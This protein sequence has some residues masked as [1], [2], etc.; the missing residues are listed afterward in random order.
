M[1]MLG[2]GKGGTKHHRKV[3]R[4]NIYGITKPA[5]RRLSRREGMKSIGDLSYKEA[6]DTLKIFWDNVIHDAIT[7]TEHARRKLTVMDVVYT[8]KRKPKHRENQNPYVR[9]FGKLKTR[10]TEKTKI[11]F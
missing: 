10:T 9:R 11:F 3:L 1:K 8:V 4:D 5:I 6:H 7:Y 2:H